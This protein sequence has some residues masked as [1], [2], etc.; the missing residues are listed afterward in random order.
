MDDKSPWWGK[1]Q[2]LIWTLGPVTV[3]FFLF[4]FVQFGWLP[5]PMLT[6]V[7]DHLTILE[8]N[9]TIMTDIRNTVVKHTQQDEE[10][11]RETLKALRQICRN[12]AK[13]DAQ[14]ERCDDMHQ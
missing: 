14:R 6:A 2:Q 4:I 3:A 13:S 7:N 9:Q 5:S 1:L 10:Q 8:R 11:R 12:T